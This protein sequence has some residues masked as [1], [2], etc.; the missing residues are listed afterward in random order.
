MKLSTRSLLALSLPFLSGCVLAAGA[1]VGY[2]VYEK[3]LN[4]NV[5]EAQ[6]KDEV[7]HVW[8]SVQETMG[9]LI[10]PKTEL[11]VH[12]FPRTIEAKVDG[13][14]VRVEVETYDVQRTIIR[15]RAEKLL[16]HDSGTASVVINKILDRLG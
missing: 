13:A 10:D 14:A 3:A 1:G 15:V 5:H 8:A 12:T 7:D 2:V 6:V 9:I 16:G 11:K 4:D